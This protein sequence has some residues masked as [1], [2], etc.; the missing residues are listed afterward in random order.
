MRTFQL[1]KISLLIVTLFFVVVS[2]KN[3]NKEESITPPKSS[4]E[5]FSQTNMSFS[6]EAGE[7]T[8]SFTANGDWTVDVASTSGGDVWCK[9]S[10]T[11]GKAGSQT[12]K[13]TTTENET[14]DDRS[15][16]VTLKSGDE[17]RTFVVTQKQKNAILINSNK[18]EVAQKGGA[19]TVEVKANVNYTA[20]I[21]ETCQDWI[22]ESS[23]TRALSTTEKTYSI[24]AN[25]DNEKREGTITFMSGN[26]SETVHVYQAGGDIILLSKNEY[27]VD[28]S[29]E[30]ITVEL[31]SN[32]EY[33]VEMPDVDWI[34]N[35]SSRAMSSHTLYYTIDVN[36]TYDNREAKIVYRNKKND[37][38]EILTI[39]QAQ[40]NAIILGQ[41]EAIIE[42]DGEIIEVKLSANVDY[43]P[44]IRN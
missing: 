38:T 6:E 14:Y 3:D 4:I 9:A 11:K 25:E 41:K 17:S 23:N 36:E 7:Q 20:T 26:I 27:Y 18:I 42:A 37:V 30:D 40:K 34:H 43:E 10:P 22:T 39:V 28:A 1:I 24:A 33:E 5:D 12:V 16:T 32:C 8:F 13:I 21:G 31:R 29:G 19:I 35:I 44:Q 15:V 2:C